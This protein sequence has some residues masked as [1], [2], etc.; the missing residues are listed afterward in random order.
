MQAD[1]LALSSL[2]AR[3]AP[4]SPALSPKL[5][6]VEVVVAAGPPEIVVSG[7]VVSGGGAGA[8][9]V[10]VCVAGEAS[11]LPAASV[12]RAEKVWEPRVRPE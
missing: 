3:V 6:E 8:S 10:Q 1:Q 9:T 5:A 2:Q 7:A 11:V 12:A 4:D